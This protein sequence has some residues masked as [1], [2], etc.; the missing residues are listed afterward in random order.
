MLPLYYPLHHPLPPAP[1][2]TLRITYSVT[3][4]TGFGLQVVADHSVSLLLHLLHSCVE[5]L[6][7]QQQQRQRE[8]ADAGYA[9]S[10][11]G[12]DGRFDGLTG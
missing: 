8:A 5:L 10:A 4:S 6:S 7:S 12:G 11:P 2:I 1:C 9:Q 3:L